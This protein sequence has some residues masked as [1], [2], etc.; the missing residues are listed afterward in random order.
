MGLDGGCVL[1]RPDMLKKSTKGTRRDND[2]QRAAEYARCSWTICALTGESL[3]APIVVSRHGQFFN[4]HSILDAILD[5][6]L[7]K[8]LRYLRKQKNWKEVDLLGAE[9]LTQYVCPV[10][11]KTPNPGTVDSWVVLFK[12][13]H[14]FLEEALKQLQ[15]NKCPI[16]GCEFDKDDVICVARLPQKQ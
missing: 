6:S 2:R 14:L 1:K 7:P 5:N 9:T 8:R 13:G 10:S 16:C 15:A 11:S 4:R 12:C 3:I